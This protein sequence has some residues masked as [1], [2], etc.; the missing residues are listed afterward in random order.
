MKRRLFIKGLFFFP[1]CGA[2]LPADPLA[3]MQETPMFVDEVKAGRLPTVARRVPEQPLVVR[4][5]AGHDGPGRQ[6]GQLTMLVTGTSD[7]VLMTIYSY[8]RLIV[9]DG[10]FQLKPDELDHRSGVRSNSGMSLYSLTV[11]SL[12]RTPAVGRS[13]GSSGPSTQFLGILRGSSITRMNRSPSSVPFAS[14]SAAIDALYSDAH[15]ASAAT[16]SAL[17]LTAS[18]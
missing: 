8:A 1:W 7:T 16:A 4:T 3:A 6:G 11:F 14:P 13:T 9:Y 5:F 18:R 12:D 17:R 2:A 15:S 10:A